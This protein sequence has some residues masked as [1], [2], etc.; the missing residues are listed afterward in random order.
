MK[1]NYSFTKH[2]AMAYCYEDE[3]KAI[4]VACLYQAE[5]VPRVIG[6]S[7]CFVIMKDGKYLTANAEF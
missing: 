7:K 1:L 5:I 4:Q 6:N 3:D 2:D